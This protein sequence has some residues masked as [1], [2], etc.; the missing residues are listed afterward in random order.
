MQIIAICSQ[1]SSRVGH[2][3]SAR[4]PTMAAAVSMQT[5]RIVNTAMSACQGSYCIR[6]TNSLISIICTHSL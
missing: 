1:P 5:P 4:R 6:H 3:Q 2:L